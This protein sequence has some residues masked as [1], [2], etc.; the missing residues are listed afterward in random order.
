MITIMPIYVA[1]YRF[2]NRIRIKNFFFEL[3]ATLMISWKIILFREIFRYISRHFVIWIKNFAEILRI[4]F[5]KYMCNFLGKISRNFI[6]TLAAGR[7]SVV[8]FF[9]PQFLF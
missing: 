9:T 3:C 7:M 1:L 2:Q 8:L 6:S 4:F 5:A